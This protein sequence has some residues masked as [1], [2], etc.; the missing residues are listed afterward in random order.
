MPL[1]GMKI[2]GTEPGLLAF[3]AGTTA[4]RSFCRGSTSIGSGR[5]AYDRTWAPVRSRRSHALKMRS[6]AAAAPGR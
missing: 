4:R 5:R 6:R 3:L 1:A 2:G